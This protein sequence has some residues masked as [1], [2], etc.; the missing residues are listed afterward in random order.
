M[1]APAVS[2][3]VPTRNRASALRRS[4]DALRA[5][6]YP[7]E[8]TEVVVV[9]DGCT[10]ETL[11]MVRRYPAPFSL[12]CITQP[13]GG[14]G[15][16]R[17]RG[18]SAAGGTLLVFLED[19]DVEAAPGLVAA[20][21]A[22]QQRRPGGVVIGRL[23]PLLGAQRGFFRIAL[24][25]WWEAKFDAL[26]MPGHRFH[27]F[28]LLSG[29]FSLGA[30]LFARCGGFDPSLR[31]HED[32]ELGVRLMQSG[33]PFL[34][35][36][37]ALGSHHEGTDLRRALRRKCEEGQADVQIGRRHPDLRRA[38][39]LARLRPGRSAR[40][41]LFFRLAFV[42]PAAGDAAAGAAARTLDLL[43]RLRLR[44]RWRRLLDD[45]LSYWYWR[46][47]AQELPTAAELARFL[48]AASSTPAP[49]IEVDL[50]AGIVHAQRQ[51]DEARPGAVRLRL[52]PQPLARI[53]PQPGAEPLRGEHLLPLLGTHLAR[54][55]LRA[56]AQ[57]GAIAPPFNVEQLLAFCA[58][59]P[60]YDLGDHGIVLD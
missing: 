7:P 50:R 13:H 58:L 10:D 9:A 40:S 54:P 31:C 11:E 16:A 52:G 33:V 22:A 5:Q 4:L 37:D 6:T 44:F 59:P 30:D 43:E 60:R 36:P 3:I 32:Y 23:P 42:R 14:A 45:L 35:A 56:L 27:A 46:G 26:A 15:A 1:N 24:R 47:V 51:L 2:V 18:A 38:L 53:L 20:H 21:V 41:R 49:E 29:N 8:R 19:D 55:L 57:D 48:P 12:R 28:D 39:P 25:R 17:N 34:Y